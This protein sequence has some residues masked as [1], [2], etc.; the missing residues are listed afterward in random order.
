MRKVT[1]SQILQK[2]V[3]RNEQETV[4]VHERL[5]KELKKAGR[6]SL[7]VEKN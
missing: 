5:R 3:L 2:R 7:T 4:K 6:V 1:A